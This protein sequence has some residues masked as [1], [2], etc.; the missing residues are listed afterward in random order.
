M[1]ES[2]QSLI[3]KDLRQLKSGLFY[4]YIRFIRQVF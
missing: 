2:N 1:R 3:V 4:M